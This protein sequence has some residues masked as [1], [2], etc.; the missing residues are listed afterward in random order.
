[1]RLD[2]T[3]P[4]VAYSSNGSSAKSFA[5]PP[6]YTSPRSPVTSSPL[7]PTTTSP[8]TLPPAAGACA[9]VP[10]WY[11]QLHQDVTQSSKHRS[12]HARSRQQEFDALTSPHAPAIVTIVTRQSRSPVRH[13]ATVQVFEAIDEGKSLCRV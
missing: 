3:S 7:S 12:T 6:P 10:P 2:L 4:V 1:M 13:K 9:K 5:S 8:M 11:R